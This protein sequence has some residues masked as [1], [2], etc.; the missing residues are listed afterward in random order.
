MREIQERKKI[1][2]EK[3]CASTAVVHNILHQ[4]AKVKERV[5]CNRGNNSERDQEH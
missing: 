4:H 3:N 1:L 5:K 2:I